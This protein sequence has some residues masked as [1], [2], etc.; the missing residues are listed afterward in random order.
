MNFTELELEPEIVKALEEQG[1]T[2]PTEIQE[3]TIPLV[4]EG[5]D[6]IGKSATG[7]GKTLAFGAPLLA[8][9]NRGKGVQ[10]LILAPTR[11][12]AVQISQELK[13]FSRYLPRSIATIYGGVSLMP[14][15]DQMDRAEIIVATPGRMLDHLERGNVDLSSV[16]HVVLDEADKMV[17]MGFI[18]D[19]ERILQATPAEKQFLLFGATISTEIDRMKEQH[20]HDPCVA[21]AE[22]YVEGDVLEQY[23]YNVEQ[24]QKFSLLLHLLKKEEVK[25]GIIFCSTRSTVELVAQNLQ[26]YK[27]VVGMLHGKLSQNRRLQV[28]RE[29]NQGKYALLVASAVAARGLDIKEV[30]H[31]FN[32]DL[33]ADPQEYIH[34][35]GRTARAGEQGKAFTLL[36]TRDHDAFRQVLDR[37]RV[38]VQELPLEQFPQVRFNARSFDAQSSE[39]RFNQRPRQ[40]FPRSRSR[41]MDRGGWERER[42]WGKVARSN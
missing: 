40:H 17:E 27:Q 33:S 41:S 26:D 30:T 2:T 42:N 18:E 25:R 10:L 5:K 4:L 9:L 23:Y 15:V 31:I 6:V 24:W 39:G 16:H 19:V 12:L 38:E 35:V 28:M 3:K 29:F 8:K 20:M 7:S 13:K 37:Y 22:A 14:Q 1:I 34:R 11:E 21:E 32:Y 36:S